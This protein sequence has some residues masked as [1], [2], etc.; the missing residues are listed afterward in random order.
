[1]NHNKE[2]SDIFALFSDDDPVSFEIIDSSRSETD[3][4]HV[5]IAVSAN[6]TKS[7][8]KLADN[9]FTFPEKIKM[10]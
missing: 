2:L 1:M 8:L 5:I 6:G 10:W 4:R 7:I 3:F 9:D